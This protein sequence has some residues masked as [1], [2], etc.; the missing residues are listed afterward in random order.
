MTFRCDAVSQY[1][2]FASD[3]VISS[4]LV[5][6]VL[7]QLFTKYK[8]ASMPHLSNKR[9]VFEVTTTQRAGYAQVNTF[10]LRLHLLL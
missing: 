9:G 6:Y 3:V 2:S 7:V 8:A 5:I 4:E 1:L 10:N